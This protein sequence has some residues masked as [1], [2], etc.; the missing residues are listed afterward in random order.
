VRHDYSN[1]HFQEYKI[2]V[3]D[4]T[5]VLPL[6]FLLTIQL[7]SV[8]TPNLIFVEL[9]KPKFS[10]RCRSSPLSTISKIQDFC[11][12]LSV[13]WPHRS[14]FRSHQKKLIFL[15][16]VFSTTSFDKILLRD[17]ASNNIIFMFFFCGRK[18]PIF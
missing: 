9:C 5:T 8:L 12:S 15:I 6:Q 18:P 10:I 7:G 3:I 17:T 13:S 14:L 1:G 2:I 16:I 11:A 4:C